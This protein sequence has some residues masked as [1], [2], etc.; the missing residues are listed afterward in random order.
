MVRPAGD[1]FFLTLACSLLPVEL[2]SLQESS[3]NCGAA[4]FRNSCVMPKK[5]RIPAG[6]GDSQRVAIF[7]IINFYAP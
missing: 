2:V 6:L 3:Q 5:G 1:S 4:I 7:I